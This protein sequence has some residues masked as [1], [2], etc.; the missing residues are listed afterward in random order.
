MKYFLIILVV[1]STRS[2][3]QFYVAE[4]ELIPPSIILIDQYQTVPERGFELWKNKWD[5]NNPY[6][7]VIAIR[8][9]QG[10]LYH[11]LYQ[12]TF[13]GR[14]RYFSYS[15]NLSQVFNRAD[16]PMQQ[17]DKCILQ[18]IGAIKTL[19][20]ANAVIECFLQRLAYCANEF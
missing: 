19:Q 2:F 9:Q 6:T 13:S 15:K 11:I 4:K 16:R 14:L 7:R 12:E 20:E 10:K 8:D 17:F 1:T 18:H 5:V 3:A